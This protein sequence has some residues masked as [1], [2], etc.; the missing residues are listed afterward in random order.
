MKKW[1]LFSLVFL[2]SW[3]AQTQAQRVE[4][5]IDSRGF[6]GELQKA[7]EESGIPA[8]NFGFIT[9]E[10]QYYSQSFGHA[11]WSEEA[12]L[13]A[14][15]IFRIASMTKALTSV[16]VLQLWEQGKVDLDAMV[17]S[18][19]PGIDSIP[20]LTDE[21][22]LVAASRP[23]TLRNLLTHTSGF[24]YAM[25][26]QRLANFV[27]PDN[28]PHPDYPRVAEPGEQWIYSTSTD[29]A[30][31][32]VEAV[33]GLDLEAYLREHIT[34]PLGMDH[35]WFNVPDSL[36][37]LIVSI[38]T[39]LEEPSDTFREYPGRVPREPVKEYSGGGGLFSSLNDYLKFLACILNEG[40]LGG[41]RILNEATVDLMFR[42]ELPGVLN[43]DPEEMADNSRMAH[44]LSWAIQLVD[45]DFG[46]KA[47][48]AY[49][50]GY[51]NTY[52]SIDRHSGVAVVVMANYL[53]FLEPG[54]L[55]LYKTFESLVRGE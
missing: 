36:Q 19:I 11:V 39:R 32:V 51:F 15:H 49:W 37:H 14:D 20:I 27:R 5:E 42:D 31:K 53:P 21:G 24:S 25:F 45:N 55:G 41:K 46:R 38:G 12:A 52:Y 35:T 50:S 9:R 29:W 30:G 28:W 26:D 1:L 10:G 34:G 33:S 48:S 40:E 4:Q 3:T 47:G 22:N 13:T 54:I 18:F 23:I 44:S 43:L 8:V 16:A 6:S 7:W 2:L 17:A